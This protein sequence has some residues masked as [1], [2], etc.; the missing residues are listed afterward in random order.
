MALIPGAIAA[1]VVWIVMFQ[2][3]FGSWYDFKEAVGY[4]L[5]PDIISW[6]RGEFGEDLWAELRLTLWLLS[7]LGAGFGITML[8]AQWIGLGS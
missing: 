6:L 1:V 8:T 5:M 2:I 4:A 7:G 3:C